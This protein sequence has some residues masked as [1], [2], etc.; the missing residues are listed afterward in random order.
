MADA[1]DTIDLYT[2]GAC[3]G[4]PGPGGWGVVIV[5][6]GAAQW[7]AGRQERTTNN[8][9]ELQ[10]AIKGLHQ[11]PPQCSVAV[12]SDSQ[13]LVNTY[14]KRWQRKANLDLWQQLD[15]L[16]QQ[17][18]VSWEWVKGH[19]GHPLNEEADRLAVAATADPAWGE[20]SGVL[21]EP[22]QPTTGDSPSVSPSSERVAASAHLSHLDEGGNAR[23]VDVGAKPD[24]NREATAKGAVSMQAETL[25]LIQTGGIAKGDVFTVAQVAGI[26]AAKKT[27]DLIPMCHPLPISG[28]DVDFVVD[29]AR[30]CVEVTAT[31]RT[32]GKTGVE[33]EALTAVS[34]AAL[35][36]YDM[37]KAVDR[38][39][40]IGDVRVVHKAGGKSGT[41]QQD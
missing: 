41:F 13:Y 15:D 37:C 19:A 20:R 16:I 18:K 31:V 32:T 6:N 7:L 5:R 40:R 1:I 36:I 3:S 11:T 39:M 22:A 38:S 9:M 26:M 24:T 12:Y 2:D 33:M 35:T 30:S 25:R 4:N 29:N 28:V 17:R 23:M 8:R 34:T 27:S 21:G 14:N 10:A